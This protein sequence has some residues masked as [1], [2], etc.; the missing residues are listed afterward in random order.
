MALRQLML[1]KK[2]DEK[3]K[4][5]EA[6]EEAAKGFEQ[7]ESD[8]E[9]A[10]NEAES[11]EEK[12]TVEAEVEAFE[13][14]KAENAEQTEQVKGELADLEAEMAETEKKAEAPE[15]ER[16]AEPEK[17]ER[18]EVMA[19]RTNFFGM[20]TREARELLE[21]E[22][23]RSFIQGTR[24]I[25]QASSGSEKRAVENVNLTIPEVLL[26]LL[27]QIVEENS[28]LMPLI[29]VRAIG[30]TGRQTI[31]GDYPEGVW[32]DCCATLNELDM[33][34]FEESWD[35]WKVGGFF[36]LCNATLEDSDLNLAAEVLTAIGVAISKA[37]D[38]AIVYGRGTRMPLGIVTRLDQ[39]AKPS[40]YLPTA[41]PW[42]DLSTSNVITGTGKTGVALFQEIASKKKV[43][44]NPYYKGGLYWLMNENTHTDLLVAS[45]D[46]NL[47]AAIVAGITT[48]MPV[49]GGGIVEVPFIPDGEIVFGYMGAYTMVERAGRKFASSEHYKFLDDRTVFKGTMR[50]DG[51]PVIAESFAVM[52]I[53]TSAP[54]KA[55][56][57]DFPADTANQS[58]S[59]G[60]TGGGGTNP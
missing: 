20:N 60:S 36:D 43:I 58:S 45:M 46:K 9:A 22:D 4:A 54:T 13:K 41:R 52:S 50:V 29:T 21:R 33:G 15:A 37:V 12:E 16:S 26:P 1:R 34:L 11:D 28:I 56:A 40:D 27:R 3:R 55:S 47:N 30:G 24:N 14:E 31:M 19:T 59:G 17:R 32:T 5:L 18:I 6:L 38:K 42:V 23:V 8:L 39:T 51:K 7:R 53:T 35:C 57:I 49:V 2:I 25:M 44:A 48:E 10:I